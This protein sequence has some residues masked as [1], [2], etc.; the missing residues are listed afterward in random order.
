MSVGVILVVLPYSKKV[1]GSSLSFGVSVNFAFS[2]S[3]LSFSYVVGKTGVLA[4]LYKLASCLRS[5]VHAWFHCPVMD[6]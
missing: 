5:C 4:S 1:L 3:S 6:W 2:L